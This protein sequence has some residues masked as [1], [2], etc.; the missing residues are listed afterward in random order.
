MAATGR[1]SARTKSNAADDDDDDDE[2]RA[3]EEVEEEEEEEKVKTPAATVAASKKKKK[4]ETKDGKK[5]KVINSESMSP[6]KRTKID[7]E[8]EEGADGDGDDRD[9]FGKAKKKENGVKRAK[10]V[11]DDDADDDFDDEKK[12]S[13]EIQTEKKV[14]AKNDDDNDEEND[15]DDDD[16]LMKRGKTKVDYAAVA[17]AATGGSSVPVIKKRTVAV[18]ETPVA[19]VERE[20][21]EYDRVVTNVPPPPM[22][23]QSSGMNTA[24]TAITANAMNNGIPDQSSVNAMIAQAQAKAAELAAMAMRGNQQAEAGTAGY[25]GNATGGGSAPLKVEFRKFDASQQTFVPPGQQNMSSGRFGSGQQDN[26]FEETRTTKI[27]CPQS[28]VGKVI[29]KGGETIK[30]LSSATGAKVVID[31]QSMADGEPRKI[32]ITGTEAQIEKVTKMCEE[33]MNGPH[34]TLTAVQAAQ[35]GAVVINVE[36]PKE[37]VGRVIGRGGETI[38]GIQLATGARAQIDQTCTPCLVIIS[39]DPQY[40]NVC[41]QVV[42]EIINGGSVAQF[43]ELARQQMMGGGMM[44]MGGGA[45]G[46]MQSQQQQQLYQQQQYA[47]QQAMIAQQQQYYQQQ[48][49]QQQQQGGPIPLRQVGEWSE[50]DDGSGRKYYYS[51]TTGASQWEKPLGFPED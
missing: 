21:E 15:D 51:T 5:K 19:V 35:P 47:M 18:I 24:S 8:E 2:A 23:Q 33:I 38:K 20:E 11:T 4:E 3:A 28:L 27:D 32:V 34:G 14:I 7:D 41:Q 25:G 29:G 16:D 45:G 37:C 42:V 6:K 43:N 12:N 49:Q 39:G 31:Q 48:Q 26:V 10:K 17:S 44:G 36:C 46:G 13:L 40:V 50:L 22:M 30:G 1:R 9:G